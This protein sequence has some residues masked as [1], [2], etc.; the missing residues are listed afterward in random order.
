MLVLLDVLVI[1]SAVFMAGVTGKVQDV[2]RSIGLKSSDVEGGVL[3]KISQVDCP[4]PLP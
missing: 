3:Q 4:S 2:F 1:D